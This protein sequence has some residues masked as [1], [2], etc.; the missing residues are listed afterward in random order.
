MKIVWLLLAALVLSNGYHVLNTPL[1]QEGEVLVVND[2][3]Y[4]PTAKKL[5]D[6]ADE[7]IFVIAFEMKYY[8]RY[9]DSKTNQL[10]EALIDAQNRGVNV[11]VL[12]DEYLDKYDSGASN[13]VRMLRQKGVDARLDGSERTTHAKVLVV[14]GKYVLLGST[15]WSFTS[16]EKNAEANVLVHSKGLASDFERYF[17]NLRG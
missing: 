14:D 7:S 9:P 16:F 3:D 15:N 4:Y 6:D 17:N 12:T 11:R 10:I 13:L 1:P 8:D 2:Q 5:I